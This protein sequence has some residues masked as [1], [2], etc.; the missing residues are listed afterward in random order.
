MLTKILIFL[1]VLLGV[2]IVARMGAASAVRKNLGA[3]R[4]KA[5]A[6][7]KAEDLVQCPA[8]G[9]WSA[10]GDVCPCRDTP[11]TP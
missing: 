7:R 6:A 2:F 1:A 5:P 11:P 3:G 8:C 4:K 9:A 10:R